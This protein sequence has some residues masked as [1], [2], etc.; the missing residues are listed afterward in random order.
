MKKG[1]LAF[2][3]ILSLNFMSFP[4]IHANA[5]ND[6][7]ENQV[8]NVT[9]PEYEEN[10]SNTIKLSPQQ[11]L[12]KFQNGDTMVVYCGYKECPYC[13]MF[14]PILHKFINDTGVPVY[15]F[16]MDDVSPD[17]VSQDFVNMIN[18]TIGLKATP[19]VALLK[20]GK[21]IHEYVGGK[22]SEDRLMTLTKYRY[23]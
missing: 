12:T 8:T 22:I 9:I 14:S 21:L 19:T 13:R 7:E 18:Q 16:D 5:V 17:N 1:L 15:Y 10:V 4:M 11:L 20:H 6:V 3:T 2:I 23:N